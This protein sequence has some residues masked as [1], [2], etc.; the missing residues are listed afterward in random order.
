MK[1]EMYT[2]QSL[3]CR[4]FWR[5]GG[6]NYSRRG[7]VSFWKSASR[8][9]CLAASISA[10]AGNEKAL[11]SSETPRRLSQSSANWELFLFASDLP[12]ASVINVHMSSITWH[13][14]ILA[15]N[16]ILIVSFHAG[17]RGKW[18]LTSNIVMERFILPHVRGTVIYRRTF[19]AVWKRTGGIMIDCKQVSWIV[20]LSAIGRIKREPRPFINKNLKC[21]DDESEIKVHCKKMTV[22]SNDKK[23]YYSKNL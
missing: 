14:S 19:C 16:S 15:G 6:R 1:P 12:G 4:S 7:P 21:N 23:K 10:H 3:E 22:I 8:V 20:C 17:W 13:Y 9:W 2:C 18:W 5:L 11:S